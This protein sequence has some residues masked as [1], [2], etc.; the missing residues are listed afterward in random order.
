MHAA[1]RTE[2]TMDLQPDVEMD[3]IQRVLRTVD[4]RGLDYVRCQFLD[5][6][7][8]ARGRAIRREYLPRVMEKGLPFAQVNNTTD[9]DDLEVELSYGCQAGDFWAVPDPSSFVVLPYATAT[10]HMFTDLVGRD[11]TPWPTCPRT[12]LR[13]MAE[14]V[15]REIGTV[16]LGFEQ[17]GYLLR[18]EGDTFVPVHHGKHMAAELLDAEDH[19]LRDLSAVLLGMGIPLEKLTSEGGLGMFEVNF[20]ADRPVSSVDQYFRFKQAFRAVARQHG[21]MGTFMPKPIQ[22]TSGAGLHVHLS[23]V[24]DASGR[25]LLADPSD[26]QGLGLSHLAYRFIAGLLTHARAIT[27]IGSPSVNSYKRLQ[28]ASFAPTH[29]TYGVGNRS[30][31]VRVVESR[32]DCGPPPIQRLEVRSP[33]GTCNPYLLG[34]VL[35]A[36]GL[37]GVRRELNPGPP[38][39]ADVGRLSPDE[40][41]DRGIEHLPRSLDRALDGLEEDTVLQEMVGTSLFD[42]F[43]KAKRVEWEKFSA[44]IT[45]WEYRQYTEFY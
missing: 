33:D 40:L 2:H 10:G 1:D 18:Q 14:L 39:V 12:A 13:G 44:Y 4:E 9:I 25:D 11:G 35:L 21:H 15:D 36:A 17:E 24:D 32:T 22:T 30:S 7:A 5:F 37:D 42:L 43:L 27:A 31:L 34:A 41:Y 8:V 19:F 20:G 29:I 38:S 6:I 45:D 28:P 26:P 23:L 16:R 3:P